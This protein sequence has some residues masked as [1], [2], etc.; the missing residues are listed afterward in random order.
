M[1]LDIISKSTFPGMT[2][3]GYQR[4]LERSR[5][6][7]CLF[8]HLDLIIFWIPLRSI[9]ILYLNSLV[10]TSQNQEISPVLPCD[11]VV[12]HAF[13]PCSS[14]PATGFQ[15]VQLCP[16]G[17]ILLWKDLGKQLSIQRHLIK[18]N[19][20]SGL[21]SLASAHG[22]CHFLFCG[23]GKTVYQQ[24]FPCHSAIQLE[25]CQEH[26]LF[27]SLPPPLLTAVPQGLLLAP[28]S[29]NTGRWRNT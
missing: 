23:A 7:S 17:L 1:K 12:L 15:A 19:R 21:H 25:R 14:T 16:D 28:C 9:A 26:A 8:R 18:A 22:N 6:G 11:P 2:S 13:C 29:Q 24:L 4:T 27:L 3:G 20:D 10:K 5:E